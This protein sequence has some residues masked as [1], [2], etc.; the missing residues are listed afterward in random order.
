MEYYDALI[1]SLGAVF[2][3]RGRAIGYASRQP[4]PHEVRY[5]TH[6]LDL[7]VVVFGLKIW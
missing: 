5:P 3:Q 1:M 6:D 4:K 2:M 7:G